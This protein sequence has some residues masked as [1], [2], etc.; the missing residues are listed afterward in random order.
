MS[1]YHKIFGS[2]MFFAICDLCDSNKRRKSL[3]IAV[4]L[5]FST[6]AW[7]QKDHIIQ[8]SG[9]AVAG[10]SLIPVPFATVYRSN[11]HRGTFTDYQGYFTIPAIAGDTLHFVFIGLKRSHFQ[12]P[13]DTESNHIS[14]VQWMEQDTLELPTVNILPYPARHRLRADILALDLPGDR[15]YKFSRDIVS[16]AQLDG[17]QDLS[18]DAFAAQDERVSS[19]LNS[20]FRSGGNLLDASAWS[21]FVRSIKRKR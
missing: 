14:I 9:I 7:S 8:V 19:R 21:S 17:L 15:Y 5:I 13:V 12:V 16:I 2:L 6:T 1:V 18:A 20:G 10:D 4:I 11:D 3:L